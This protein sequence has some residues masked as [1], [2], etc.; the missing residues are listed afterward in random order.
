MPLRPPTTL[1]G[2]VCLGWDARPGWDYL[3]FSLLTCMHSLSQ[4]AIY[5]FESLGSTVVSG[6]TERDHQYR[7]SPGVFQ[8]PA[9]WPVARPH[10][11]SASPAD[12]RPCPIESDG[13]ASPKLS[14]VRERTLSPLIFKLVLIST[15]EGGS[16]A[17]ILSPVSTSC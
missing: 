6:P 7:R 16:G 15:M 11:E 13:N 17:N 5:V 12:L 2:F 1:Y 4:C 10:H 9:V 3:S 14:K 8:N